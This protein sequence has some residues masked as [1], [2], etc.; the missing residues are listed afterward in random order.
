MSVE[1]LVGHLVDIVSRGGNFL[2]NVGP[3]ANGEL[4]EIQIKI[5]TELAAWMD[6]DSD[7]IH[8][9][10][11]ASD[12][13]SIGTSSDGETPWLGITKKRNSVFAFVKS[14]GEIEFEIPANL[15]NKDS[16]KILGGRGLKLTRTGDKLYLQLGGTANQLPMV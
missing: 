6:I 3:K 7:A 13:T 15:V 5:L 9:S 8:G 4:P 14:A 16:A 2:L 1:H 11:M 10:E 12:F